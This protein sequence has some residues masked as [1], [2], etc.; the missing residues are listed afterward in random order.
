MVLTDIREHGVEAQGA[1]A[2]RMGPSLPRPFRNNGGRKG[3]QLPQFDST[4]QEIHYT[5]WGTVQSADNPDWGG[6]RIVTGSDGSAYYS[7]THYQTWI[8]MEAGR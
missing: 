5:E 8:V 4:G 6:E 3:Y 2:Q 7:P 1:G